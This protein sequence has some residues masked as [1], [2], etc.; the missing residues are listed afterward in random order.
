MSQVKAA[1][2][3][4]DWMC[5]F[6]FLCIFVLVRIPRSLTNYYPLHNF[7][8]VCELK[9]VLIFLLTCSRQPYC[10]WCRNGKIGSF[11]HQGDGR[12]ARA[13]AWP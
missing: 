3:A 11:R 12:Y 4:R 13:N 7:L 6:L 10:E 5:L 1:G 8:I 2:L 9:H